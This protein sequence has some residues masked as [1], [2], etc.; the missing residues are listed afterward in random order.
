MN[1]NNNIIKCHIPLKEKI[2]QNKNNLETSKIN[3]NN[4]TIEWINE[5]YNN[6]DTYLEALVIPSTSPI[7]IKK[8]LIVSV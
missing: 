4:K 2:Y 3:E 6:L 5:F 1:I 7:R 8:M